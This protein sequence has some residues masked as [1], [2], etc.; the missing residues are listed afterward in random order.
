[1]PRCATIFFGGVR[2]P[3]SSSSS[4]Y[5]YLIFPFLFCSRFVVLNA[6]LP[7]K[8]GY[9]FSAVFVDPMKVWNVLGKAKL[10]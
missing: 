7:L 4:S 8:D 10:D 5:S 1:M 6:I 2:S 3:S 9:C